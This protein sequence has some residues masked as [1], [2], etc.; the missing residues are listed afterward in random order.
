MLDAILMLVS[1]L[2]VLVSASAFVAGVKCLV[3]AERQVRGAQNFK[4]ISRLKADLERRPPRTVTNTAATGN[5]LGKWKCSQG[6]TPASKT[7]N[8][9]RLSLFVVP[10]REFQMREFF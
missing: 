8:C 9:G 6:S 7:S 5:D 1:T 10:T 3:R 2:Q 4:D